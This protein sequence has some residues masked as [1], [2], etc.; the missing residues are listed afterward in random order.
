MNTLTLVQHQA[1]SDYWQ[2][3]KPKVVLVMLVTVWIGMLLANGGEFTFSRLLI[4]TIGL[5]LSMGSAAAINHVIDRQLDAKMCR[6]LA[7]P[8]A[9]GRVAPIQALCFAALLAIS[10]LSILFIWVN[11]LTGWLTLG[12]VVVYAVIYT[13]FLKRATPQNIVIGGLAGALPPLLGWTAVTGQLQGD[14]LLLVLIVFSWTPPHFWSLAVYRYQDYQKAN[15][16]MLPV[17]HGLAFTRNF[18]CLYWLLMFVITLLPVC[19]GFL[20]VPYL[21][22]ALLLGGWFGWHC[23]RMKRSERPEHA[24]QTFKVSIYYLLLLF[25]AMGVERVVL[26]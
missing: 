22:A 18:I 19:T 23:W 3:T 10:G 25:T 7:R 26:G 14:A 20:G 5:A 13:G 12:G 24:W 4:S 8:V 21:I 15:V 9:S 2:L 1:W 16:P 11:S 6:T 17:T